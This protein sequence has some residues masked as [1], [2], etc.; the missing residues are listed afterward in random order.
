M[1]VCSNGG[2]V[3]VGDKFSALRVALRDVVTVLV[4]VFIGKVS[5]LSPNHCGIER[6]T[7]A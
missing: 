1:N 2:A 7:A 4:I 3:R 6:E 5:I